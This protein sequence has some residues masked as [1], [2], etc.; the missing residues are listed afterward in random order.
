VWPFVVALIVALVVVLEVAPLATWL[1][2]FM[3]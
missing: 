1:P 3:D 2:G